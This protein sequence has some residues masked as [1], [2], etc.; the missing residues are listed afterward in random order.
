MDR[1]NQLRHIQRGL[2]TKAASIVLECF[3]AGL[4]R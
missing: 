1:F 4:T 3:I 2:M